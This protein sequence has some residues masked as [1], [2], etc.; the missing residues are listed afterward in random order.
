M[1]KLLREDMLRKLS[2]RSKLILFMTV[3]I[4]IIGLLNIYFY[5]KTY[6]YVDEYNK[7]LNDYIQVNSLSIQL[8]EGR[9]CV[10]KFLSTG[11]YDYLNE[12]YEYR[13]KIG[14]LSLKVHESSD[15]LDTYLLSNAIRN[16]LQSYNSQ[17]EEAVN[18][19]WVNGDTYTPFLQAKNI[20]VYIGD[21]IK[22]LLYIKLTE[23]QWYHEELTKSVGTI[24]FINFVS[25]TAIMILSFIYVVAFSKSITIPIRRLAQFAM[26]VAHGD[27]E[28]KN[29]NIDSSDEINILVFAFN[30]MATSIQNMIELER[31]LHEEELKSVNISKQLNQARYQ[32]LQSQINPHF[33]F[34]TLNT[35]MRISMFEKANKTSALIQNLS[36]IF[37]YNLGN[38]NKEVLLN[39][40]IDII[41]EYIHIQQA[42]FGE[43]IRFSFI[44]RGD[45]SGVRIPRFII[46]PLVENSIV[47]GLEPKESGG[48]VRIKVYEKCDST[49]IKI[50]DNGIGI[51][52]D[53][54]HAITKGTNESDLSRNHGMGINN[55]RDRLLIY[56]K[57]NRCF[58]IKS[59]E[60]LG[61]VVTI[62]IIKGV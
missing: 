2:I 42:R 52:K 25:F 39:E 13:R 5:S 33:L 27:F 29:L 10:S 57:D 12:F 18:M 32:A 21:Y 47:H 7:M 15:T 43:R 1:Y 44:C 31:K 40:E 11:D 19:A 23:G 35:I 34:N 56:Y 37:R 45:I 17:I 24:R 36:N 62:I 60:G 30:K 58:N 26:H 28:T 48:G 16:S 38:I 22:Q 61:T 9:E 20:S 51:S 3:I 4:V 55:V 46:Q 53:K 6:E 59:H 8:I 54:L 41:K 49:V 14:Q 50:I